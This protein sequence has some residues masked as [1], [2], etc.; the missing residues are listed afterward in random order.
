LS[1]SDRI[2]RG[3]WSSARPE[4]AGQDVTPQRRRLLS[5]ANPI[6]AL[7]SKI[8][9]PAMKTTEP[10]RVSRSPTDGAATPRRM[11]TPPTGSNENPNAVIARPCSSLCLMGHRHQDAQALDPLVWVPRTLSHHA[12]CTYSCRRPPSRSRRRAEGRAEGGGVRHGGRVLIKRSVR[13]V[14]V[15]GLD[16]LPAGRTLG[17]HTITK[18]QQLHDRQARARSWLSHSVRDHRVINPR[19]L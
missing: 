4:R 8:S 14:G 2:L 1:I 3:V 11:R 10:P 15:V 19:D 12:T 5:F 9:T 16:V 6:T 18:R 7:T 17:L 13:A